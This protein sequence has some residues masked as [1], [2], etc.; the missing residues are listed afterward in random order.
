LRYA[1]VA[2]VFVVKNGVARSRE[3]ET[4]ASEGDFIE[5]TKGLEPGERVITTDVDRMAD[6]V[7]VVAREA[8]A[9]S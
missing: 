7:K 2:R 3:V 1:G 9:R 6:G 5:I 4:G 8:K